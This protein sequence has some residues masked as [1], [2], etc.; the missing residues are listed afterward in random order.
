[1]RRPVRETNLN[2]WQIVECSERGAEVPAHRLPEHRYSH[3]LS[4]CRVKRKLAEELGGSGIALAKSLASRVL[5]TSRVSWVNLCFP[6]ELATPSQRLSSPRLAFL[7]SPLSR[8]VMLLV[9]SMTLLQLSTGLSATKLLYL[10]I[11]IVISVWSA[12]SLMSRWA[13]LRSIG[14][15]GTLWPATVVG[16]LVALSAIVARIHG[17]DIGSWASDVSAYGM[18]PAGIVIGLDLAASEHRSGSVALVLFFAGLVSALIYA[19]DWTGRHGVSSV[20][21]GRYFFMSMFLPAAAFCLA[22]AYALD[23]RFRYRAIGLATVVLLAVFIAGSRSSLVFAVPIAITFVVAGRRRLGRIGPLMLGIGVALLAAGALTWIGSATGLLNLSVV[24][25]RMTRL[26]HVASDPSVTVRLSQTRA[27]WDGWLRSPWFGV[28]PGAQYS[29]GDLITRR[30]VDS[31][32]APFARFGIIGVVSFVVLL[33]T[34]TT[35]KLRRCAHWVPA[36]ALLAF[37]AMILAWGLISSPFDDKGVALGLV[38]LIGLCGVWRSETTTA[39][40]H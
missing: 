12:I 1:M 37:V 18:L 25:L 2:A 4:L 21:E 40:S 11:L 33:A 38:P 39:R 29:Y 20:A 17:I 5:D 10:A 30:P 28:G 3:V 36:T 7:A 16:L 13:L 14:G 24:G 26:I 23:G 6:V 35:S 27:L 9:S 8:T 32:M 31:P 34:L 15:V 19:F 22:L